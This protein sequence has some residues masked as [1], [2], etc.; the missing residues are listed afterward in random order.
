LAEATDK[1]PAQVQVFTEDVLVGYWTK[2]EFSG[3]LS[4]E[5]VN[6]ISTRLDELRTAVKFAREEANTI[7]VTDVHYGAAI[8]DYLFEGGTQASG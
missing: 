3:A 7:D 1:H 4:A 8:L 5:R 2:T 6:E